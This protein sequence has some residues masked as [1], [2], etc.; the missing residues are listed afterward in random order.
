[1]IILFIPSLFLNGHIFE[2]AKIIFGYFFHE[3]LEL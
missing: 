3:N 2:S 1:M